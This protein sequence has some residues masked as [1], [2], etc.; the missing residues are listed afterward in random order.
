MANFRLSAGNSTLVI[1][2]LDRLP[3]CRDLCSLS[4]ANMEDDDP[5]KWSI[6]RVVQELCTSNRSWQPPSATS[7]PDFTELASVLRAQEVTGSVLLSDVDDNVL[8]NDFNIKTLGK[9][10]FIRRAIEDLR[11]RSENYQSRINAHFRNS[12]SIQSPSIVGAGQSFPPF[13]VDNPLT[14][15]RHPQS[16]ANPLRG[17]QIGLQ[18]PAPLEE[19]PQGNN[20]PAGDEFESSDFPDSK[21]R[22]LASLNNS[23]TAQARDQ[24]S[25]I[26]Q[27]ADEQNLQDE[28]AAR[29]SPP[30]PPSEPATSP[31]SEKNVKKRKR[32][33][34]TLI[35]SH[36][37]PDRDREIPTPADDV[38]QFHPEKV[39]PGK[40]F[41]SDDG[42]KRLV[43]IHQ[44]KSEF[45]SSYNYD[46]L[47][48]RPAL[49][50]QPELNPSAETEASTKKDEGKKL[51][52]SP[53]SHAMGYLGK[54]KLPVDDI[55]YAGT[56]VGHELSPS[57]DGADFAE[58]YR[59]ISGGRRLYV[60]RVMK[61]F[62]HNSERQVFVRNGKYYSAV[63]P[64][65]SKLVPRFYKPCFT[66]YYANDKEEIL[67]KREELPFWPEVDPDAPQQEPRTDGQEN[68]VTFGLGTLN[69]LASYGD[70]FDPESLDKY[71]YVQGGDEILPIYGESDEENEY[72]PDTWAEIEEEQGMLEKP[73]RPLKNPHLSLDEVN[74]AIDESIAEIVSKWRLKKLPKQQRKARGLWTKLN[75]SRGLRKDHINRIQEHL[76]RINNDRIP[77]L[78][79]EIASEVWTSQLQVRKQTRIMEQSIFDRESLLWEISMLEGKVRPEKPIPKIASSKACKD[80]TKHTDDGQEEGESIS[81]D[82]E[83]SSSDEDIGDFVIDDS[84]S[85]EELI[86]M[87]LADSEN[88]NGDTDVSDMSI[89]TP[90]KKSRE[91]CS[92]LKNAST[93]SRASNREV[94]VSDG[95][96]DRLESPMP[97]EV[98]TPGHI[99]TPSTPI[100]S[101][102]K[103]ESAIPNARWAPCNSVSEP[104][105]LSSDDSP[106]KKRT[107][108]NLITP[109]KKEEQAKEQA[110]AKKKLTLTNGITGRPFYGGSPVV[111]GGSTIAISD[112]ESKLPDM[113]NLPPYDNPDAI[114]IFSPSVWQTVSDRSRLLI[115]L[116]SAMEDSSR[117]G[118]LTFLASVNSDELWRHMSS[119]Q[120]A[121]IVSRF[122]P[123][124]FAFVLL[125]RALKL[126]LP[127]HTRPL[128]A[129]VY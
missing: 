39:E 68:R 93:K 97:G 5:W 26:I 61:N 56:E 40:V 35:S 45:E 37:D 105:V 29:K 47:L 66:L 108:I 122:L 38:V 59:M 126:L 111:T 112:E 76:D 13:A 41:I 98:M 75:K 101:S 124:T 72:D 18:S 9:R 119:A 30:T 23:L 36:I 8:R 12:I 85:A 43:P 55:F 96:D 82:T 4:L 95:P 63:R 48:Q 92:K 28:I 60:H 49:L 90:S 77:K 87:N 100:K 58:S 17:T 127:I 54:R 34:P 120:E 14:F 42:K 33:A 22:K 51:T 65:P 104:I 11:L 78:R 1:N 74:Q 107:V 15:G 62:L 88:E 57:D 2:W 16:L 67:S 31:P 102:I 121:M 84:P 20:Q 81:S 44:P 89:S 86:E 50:Q 25:S 70:T 114:A 103:E 115:S 80:S 46:Q 24:A 19:T 116:L 118:I 99:S 113:D 69:E 3:I 32:I 52:R 109:R 73:L 129:P 79:K 125:F 27:Q 7:T 128:N 10:A 91:V 83:A 71:R 21:R 110:K 6:E 117:T 123:E 53:E 94:S 106:V 64:Y